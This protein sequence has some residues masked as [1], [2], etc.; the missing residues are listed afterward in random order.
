MDQADKAM[1]RKLFRVGLRREYGATLSAIRRCRKVRNLFAHCHWGQSENPGLFFVSLD[2]A[3]IKKGPLKLEFRHAAS[4]TLT[5]LEEYSLSGTLF[6]ALTP[7][8]KNSA[9]ELN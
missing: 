7:S 3:A 1:K 9:S 5:E 6:C 2:E 4:Q 8:G